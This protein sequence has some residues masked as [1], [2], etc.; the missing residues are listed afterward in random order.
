MVAISV[1]EAFA[2]TGQWRGNLELGQ[3]KLSLVLL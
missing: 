3:M 2:L 1:C